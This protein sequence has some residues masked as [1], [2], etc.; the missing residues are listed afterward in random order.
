MGLIEAPNAALAPAEASYF[1]GLNAELADKG[2][3]AEG[4]V[5]HLQASVQ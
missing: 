5:G 3:L 1:T 2:N 4:G